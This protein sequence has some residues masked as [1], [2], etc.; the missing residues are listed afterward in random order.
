[1]S[2]GIVIWGEVLWDRF[3]DGD[4]LGGA[5]ANVA[6]HLGQVGSWVQLVSRV[7][8]DGDGHRAIERLAEQVDVELVQVDPERATGEVT[9]EIEDGE[10]RYTLQP[11]RAWER[12]A[13]TADVKAALAEAGVLV[14]GTLAQRT[15]DGLVAWRDAIAT[16]RGLR[17]CDL[18]LRP[19]QPY[20]IAISEAIA[21]A[22]IV[23]INDRELAA[24]RE[25]LGWPEPVARLRERARLVAVTHGAG[26][27]TLYGDHAPIAI[28]GVPATPGG[29]HVGCGDAYLAIL[30]HG[31]VSGW[32]LETSGRAASRYAAAVASRRGATPAFDD[33][34]VAELLGHA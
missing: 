7:G 30:V 19:G 4:Q 12:I 31:L 29:D 17:V 13:C 10:P 9:I 26:G 23:K 24:L 6:W 27:S 5:P 15:A 18:N 33:E 8:D 16:M 28:P 3:P 25:W 22:D 14:Y 1:M 2:D 32:D 20:S 21:A 11:G 34:L